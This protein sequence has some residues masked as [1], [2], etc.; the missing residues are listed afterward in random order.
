VDWCGNNRTECVTQRRTGPVVAAAVFAGMSKRVRIRLAGETIHVIGRNI[1]V[2][3]LAVQL[4]IRRCLTHPRHRRRDPA[5]TTSTSCGQPGEIVHHSWTSCGDFVDKPRTT[6]NPP[7]RPVTHSSS[8]P[9]K[10]SHHP[11]PVSICHHAGRQHHS[12][13]ATHST[14]SLRDLTLCDAAR[15]SPARQ[16]VPD[17]GLH[18]TGDFRVAGVLARWLDGFGDF[19]DVTVLVACGVDDIHDRRAVG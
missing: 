13:G 4:V 16:V 10:R 19:Q 18:L 9:H 11:A 15:S 14:N 12:S 6:L 8:E 3:A 2:E 1:S 17:R 7:D 5:H